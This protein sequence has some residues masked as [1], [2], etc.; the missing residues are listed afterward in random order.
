MS[1]KYSHFELESMLVTYNAFDCV[2]FT[3]DT[4]HSQNVITKVQCFEFALLSQQHDHCT[5][6][7]VKTFTEQLS[8]F[9]IE[10]KK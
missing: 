8:E 9:I 10:L 4:L 7:P 1:R 3:I 6:S 5:T 2:I